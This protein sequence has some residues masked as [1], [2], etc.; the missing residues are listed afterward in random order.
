[1]DFITESESLVS[2]SF[3]VADMSDEKVSIKGIT[4]I[5][6]WSVTSF[7]ELHFIS[8]YENMSKGSNFRIIDFC[9]LLEVG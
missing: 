4:L 3:N 6:G 8:R 2:S 9:F 7:L 5:N 1:M